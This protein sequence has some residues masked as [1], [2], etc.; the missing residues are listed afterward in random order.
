MTKREL[1]H[2]ARLMYNLQEYCHNRGCKGCQIGGAFCGI[3]APLGG[4]EPISSWNIIKA[5]IERL[6]RESNALDR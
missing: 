1:A 3:L 6:E 2:I 4:G 5:D